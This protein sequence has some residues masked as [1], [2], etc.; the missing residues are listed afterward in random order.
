ML[1]A[2]TLSFTTDLRLTIDN[3]LRP[4]TWL[5]APLCVGALVR[6]RRFILR[7]KGVK[8]KTF[9]ILA[10]LVPLALFAFS[11][12]SPDE[13]DYTLL[14]KTD[15]FELREYAPY[16]VAETRVDGG[17]EEASGRAFP[18]LIN[19]IQRGNQGGLNLPMTAP[20]NQQPGPGDDAVDGASG[21][22]LFQFVM[23]KEY[24]RPMLPGPV[25][26]RV[27]LRQ[28]PARLVAARRYSGDWGEQKYRENEQAL[29]EAMRR[30]GLIATGA[31]VFARYNAPFVP[32]FMRRNEVMVEVERPSTPIDGSG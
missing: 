17:F 9:I 18:V 28:I 20:V 1:T 26:K 31:P 30:E 32:W 22:W 24:R 29:L 7:Q 19:Y 14:E 6:W 13:P 10:I 21:N 12:M 11:V 27:T 4:T 5:N 2:R 3:A 15:D 25:D 23:S 16:V 8:R